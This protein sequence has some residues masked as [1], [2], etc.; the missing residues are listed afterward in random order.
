M[1]WWKVGF[2]ILP[3]D[4]TT[5]ETEIVTEAATSRDAVLS[6]A[7]RLLID[8]GERLTAVYV[9]PPLLIKPAE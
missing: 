2:Q 3:G 9:S 5:V 8:D 1:S 4:G 7:A 6:A